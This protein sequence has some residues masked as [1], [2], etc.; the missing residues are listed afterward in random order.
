MA[1]NA[2][3]PINSKE[4]LVR[5]LILGAGRLGYSITH[6]LIRSPRTEMVVLA[7]RDADT[8]KKLK[9]TMADEKIVPV[10]LD[11]SQEEYAA[12]LMAKADVVISCLPRVLHYDMAKLALSA[13]TSFCAVENSPDPELTGRLQLL[14]EV[15]K[16]EGVA[17]IPSIG[18][19]PGLISILAISAADSLDELYEIKIRLGILPV[20]NE[21]NLDEF[22][23][24]SFNPREFL[25]PVK[26]IKEGKVLEVPALTEQ[27]S[28]DFPAPIGKT[29]AFLS[30]GGAGRL[31][32]LYKGRIRHLDFKSI[33][34]PGYLDR[35]AL[36][37]ELG[38]FSNQSLQ[39]PSGIEVVPCELT[40]KLLS[41]TAQEAA[42]LVVIKI[43]ATGVKDDKPI[44]HVF[45]CVDYGDPAE[46]IGAFTRMTAYPAS[47]IAQ[48]LAREDI[49]G[50]GVLAPEEVVPA[51]LFLAEL[52]SR[53]IRLT[54]TERAPVVKD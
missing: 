43:T 13:K 3:R 8:V 23:I 41:Q 11:V 7:D 18:L 44:Q 51:R 32:E 53:G 42:D 15:A 34:Y 21:G 31:P 2:A 17:I 33:H 47:I 26:L 48:M 10:E 6:D 12:E 29:E 19:S 4:N 16:D 25:H 50:K 14:D 9:E 49:K 5:F 37:K 27:E 28:L 30:F 36:L 52:D 40:E 45:D 54:M 1:E 39:L 24:K 38:L 35:V 20:E 22:R 46:R